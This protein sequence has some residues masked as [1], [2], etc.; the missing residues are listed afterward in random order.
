MKSTSTTLIATLMMAGCAFTPPGQHVS[1]PTEVDYGAYPSEYKSIVLEYLKEHPPQDSIES[2]SIYFLNP[3]DRYADRSYTSSTTLY[4]YRVCIQ[5]RTEAITKKSNQLHFFLINNNQVIKHASKT[6][7]ATYFDRQCSSGPQQ[8]QVPA[9]TPVA[10]APAAAPPAAAA[11]ATATATAPSMPRAAVPAH[12]SGAAAVASVRPLKYI[13]CEVDDSEMLLI[14]DHDA[15]ELRREVE[16][17]DAGTLTIETLSDTSIVATDSRSRLFLSR[18][19]GKLIYRKGD[20]KIVG[21]CESSDRTR[22]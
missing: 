21:D 12:P 20:E 6:G 11:A 7:L 19:S 15:K 1:T 14:V 3:P 8:A 17:V 2:D 9:P 16:G 4:G 18:V 13:V 22:Y 5:G 10:P